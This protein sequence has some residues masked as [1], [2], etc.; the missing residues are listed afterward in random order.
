M[1][2]MPSADVILNASRPQM[3]S[4][5][6]TLPDDVF[7]V[8]PPPVL[9]GKGKTS[10]IA[11]ELE[12]ANKAV[13]RTRFLS[14]P[15]YLDVVT[16]WLNVLRVIASLNT[17]STRL[18]PTSK[19][20]G[21]LYT[22]EPNLLWFVQLFIPGFRTLETRFAEKPDAVTC[23]RK[24]CCRKACQGARRDVRQGDNTRSI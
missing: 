9:K 1:T 22:G 24:S 13:S 11:K 3:L 17:G 5:A 6:K 10:D 14:F 19:K 16:R 15:T 20:S 4:R 21:V 12:K 18:M 7:K 2:C 8:P 23:Y